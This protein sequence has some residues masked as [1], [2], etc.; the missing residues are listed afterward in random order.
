M[1]DEYCPFQE[2]CRYVIGTWN[3]NLLS[4]NGRRYVCKGLEQIKGSAKLERM[5]EEMSCSYLNL[6]NR[7]LMFGGMI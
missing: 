3:E 7:L 5:D 2:G 6:L 1:L 4:L